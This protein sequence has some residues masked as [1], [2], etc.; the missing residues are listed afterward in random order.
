M[1]TKIADTSLATSDGS[2]IVELNVGVALAADADGINRYHGMSMS[3][4]RMDNGM[5]Q[6]GLAAA[7]PSTSL[8]ANTN[9]PFT[10]L[11]SSS[12]AATITFYVVSQNSGSN[13]F[14]VMK[15]DGSGPL[16]VT[17]TPGQLLAIPIP[18]AAFNIK[19]QSSALTNIVMYAY[20]VYSN[21]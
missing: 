13:Y 7:T 17:F 9:Q 12:A 20:A 10:L 14:Q 8:N 15:P 4:K 16:S 11:L 2:N 5:V 21:S 1:S 18:V 3:S 19:I 6:N